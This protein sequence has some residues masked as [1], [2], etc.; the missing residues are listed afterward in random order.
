MS[1]QCCW[2]LR[3]RGSKD[4]LSRFVKAMTNAESNAKGENHSPSSIT[5]DNDRREIAGSAYGAF[6]YTPGIYEAE[7]D[8]YAVCF[9]GASRESLEP[10]LT[11][12]EENPTAL[13]LQE[14]AKEFSI[15][16]EVFADTIYGFTAIDYHLFI[17]PDGT[18]LTHEEKAA[19]HEWR[20]SFDS[21]EELVSEARPVFKD[22]GKPLPDD[23]D[24]AM[25]IIAEYT[26]DEGY[27]DITPIRR[28]FSI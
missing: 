19:M 4:A 10:M 9:R 1:E 11:H 13:T 16:I 23:T 25:R 26:D 14:A 6:P 12:D 3:A 15:S 17:A 2:S 24:E 22:M 21:D 18:I 7:P 8:V 27:I 5:T 28:E 20:D